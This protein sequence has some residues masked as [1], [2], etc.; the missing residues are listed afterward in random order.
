[1]SASRVVVARP[2]QPPDANAQGNVHGG[3]ILRMMDEAA[4]IAVARHTHS[5][6]VTAAIDSFSF[7]HPVHIGDFVTVLASINWV[8]RSSLEVGVRVEAENLRTGAVTHTGTGRL[9]YVSIDEQ[10]RPKPVPPLIPET[11]DDRRRMAEAEER[12]KARVAARQPDQEASRSD[13]QARQFG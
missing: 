4:G 8:G 5:R 6:A 9:I 12:Q 3:V 11:D 1:M 13:I 10:G 7:L 2:M